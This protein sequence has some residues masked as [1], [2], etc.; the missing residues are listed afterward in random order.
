M[1]VKGKVATS[2]SSMEAFIQSRAVFGID[3]ENPISPNVQIAQ[4]IDAIFF[5]RW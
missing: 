5:A 1:T 4:I 2:K 3:A